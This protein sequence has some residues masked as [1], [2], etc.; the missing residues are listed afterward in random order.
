MQNSPLSDE[1]IEAVQGAS[2]AS[3]QNKCVTSRLGMKTLCHRSFGLKTPPIIRYAYRGNSFGT[4]AIMGL[5]YMI[6]GLL[7]AYKSMEINR[8]HSLFVGVAKQL[9]RCNNFVYF[10]YSAL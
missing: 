4:A 6:L 8:R 10:P 9:L 2:I 5:H 3:F 7:K 1:Q